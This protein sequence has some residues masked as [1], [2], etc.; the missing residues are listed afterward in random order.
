ML[1]GKPAGVANTALPAVITVRA[2]LTLR[3]KADRYEGV[4]GMVVPGDAD[5]GGWVCGRRTSDRG[6]RDGDN[7]SNTSDAWNDLRASSGKTAFI[8]PQNQITRRSST[9][10]SFLYIRSC[11]NCKSTFLEK[12][13]WCGRC[14]RVTAVRSLCS[15]TRPPAASSRRG[16]RRSPPDPGSSR[17]RRRSPPAW[18]QPQLLPAPSGRVR[19]VRLL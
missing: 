8:Q 13:R 15:C 5:G 19:A 12:V 11:G 10:C 7:N 18:L 6:N 17:R 14:R 2:R 16:C 4:G 1:A 9:L 3:R